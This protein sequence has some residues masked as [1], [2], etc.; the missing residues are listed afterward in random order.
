MAE[1]IRS[2]ALIF[3]R[4]HVRNNNR[5]LDS[6]MTKIY[7]IRLLPAELKML[8]QILASEMCESENGGE[9]FRLLL[10]REWN[11]RN[12]FPVPQPYNYQSVHR[13]SSKK[14]QDWLNRRLEQRLT[15][16]TRHLSI[17]AAPGSPA[18]QSRNTPA[19]QI[20]PSSTRAARGVPVR[21]KSSGVKHPRTTL[22]AAYAWTA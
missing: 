3:I 6:L 18:F 15:C 12:G 9:W 22:K 8:E 20:S 7:P 17:A 16:N 19:L 13:T 11:K 1:R 2:A 4:L 14:L 5:A 10:H 21:T